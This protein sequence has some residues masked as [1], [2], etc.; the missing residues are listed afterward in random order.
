MDIRNKVAIVTGGGSGLGEATTIKLAEGGAKVAVLDLNGDAANAVAER[1]V[2]RAFAIDIADAEAGETTLATIASDL[3]TP[4]ILV[5]CAGVGTPMK[6]LGKDG[7][8]SLAAF[9]K[10]VRINLIGTFSMMRPVADVISRDQEPGD[11]NPPLSVRMCG[12][13]CGVDI[14][15]ALT[16][17]RSDDH[18]GPSQDFLVVL[19]ARGIQRESSC[20][21]TDALPRFHLALVALLRNLV[22]QIKGHQRVDYPRRIFSQID[23]Y[24]TAVESVPIRFQSV[25][26]R[27]DEPDPCYPRLA[28]VCRKPRH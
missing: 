3:G 19:D 7:P 20:V 17:A 2:G 9:E 6:I 25:P 28:S 4:R 11:G 10:V 14:E 15:V 22:V 21:G 1:I 23:V 5:N 26:R 16:A 27:G 8:V 12:Q 18:V 13:N 24:A